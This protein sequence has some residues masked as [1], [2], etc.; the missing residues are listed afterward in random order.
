M[1]EMRNADGSYTEVARDLYEDIQVHIDGWFEEYRGKLSPDAI[2]HIISNCSW[3][4]AALEV[5]LNSFPE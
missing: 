2:Q 1:N 3:G 5:A 4:T